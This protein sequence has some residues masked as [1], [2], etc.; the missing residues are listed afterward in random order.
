MADPQYGPEF[1]SLGPPRGADPT[2]KSP[3]CMTVRTPD[4]TEEALRRWVDP[5]ISG[6]DSQSK[7]GA[8]VGVSAKP[9]NGFKATCSPKR[10]TVPLGPRP[11]FAGGQRGVHPPTIPAV[12]PHND[13]CC[14][15]RP[16]RDRWPS[17]HG[18]IG[19]VQDELCD[20]PR[21]L[22]WARCRRHVAGAP[23]WYG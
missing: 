16:G 15:A 18:Q 3:G 1:A 4:V 12:T 21:P 7:H 20:C 8:I 22:R 23:H 9:H 5:A 19:G 14:T 6:T 11:V 13:L 17:E 2:G 10:L